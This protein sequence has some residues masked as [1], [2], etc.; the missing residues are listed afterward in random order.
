MGR[1]WER[2]KGLRKAAEGRRN[3]E[4]FQRKEEGKFWALT[5]SLWLSL[6]WQRVCKE[7][8]KDAF[9]RRLAGSSASSGFKS[10]DVGE[11]CN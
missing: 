7:E 5:L 11:D 8:E 6:N 1:N 10:T 2:F 3:A 4:F 9:S